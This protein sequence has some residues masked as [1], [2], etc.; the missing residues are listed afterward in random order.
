MGV[1]RKSFDDQREDAIGR[2]LP[3][4]EEDVGIFS[5][6]CFQSKLKKRE[7]GLFR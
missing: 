6:G 1:W 2:R 5:N 4:I 7:K 3:A